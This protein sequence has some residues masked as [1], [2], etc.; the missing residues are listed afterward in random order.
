MI[1]L[2]QYLGP[3]ANHPD[4]TREIRSNADL[5]LDK[6]SEILQAAQS[7]GVTLHINPHTGCYVA[8]NGNGGFR[9][10]GATVGAPASKHKSGHAVD[11]YDPHREL[12]RWVWK[13]QSA[14]EGSGLHI[15]RP[16][17]TPTWLHFQDVAPGSG[18]FAFIPNASA[19]LAAKLPEQTAA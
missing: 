13:N 15:E 12:A 4:V 17:W 19:P 5:M 11:I 1:T 9:P 6:V 8:G 10:A 2:A 18:V 14:V 7:D 16:E 3:Y